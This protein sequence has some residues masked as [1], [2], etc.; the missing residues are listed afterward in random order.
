[1]YQGKYANTEPPKRNPRRKSAKRTRG[2]I[3]FYSVYAACVIIF[4]VALLCVMNPL[5]DWLVKYEASQPNYKRD[6]VFAELFADPDWEKIYELA[7][8]EDTEF[9]NSKTFA[10]CMD[11]LVGDKELTCLETSAGLSGDKKYIVK[12]VFAKIFTRMSLQRFFL[13]F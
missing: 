8:V 10:A 6:E 5:R 4:L 9:E 2:T 13:T 7:N 3:I 1:M 12:D 11:K